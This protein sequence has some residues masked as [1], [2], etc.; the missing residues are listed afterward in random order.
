M[1]NIGSIWMPLESGIGS[2][3]NLNIQVWDW[4]WPRPPHKKHILKNFRRHMEALKK[5]QLGIMTEYD[6]LVI[7]SVELSM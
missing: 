6:E 2:L 4:I 5:Q 1:N 3:K 7:D